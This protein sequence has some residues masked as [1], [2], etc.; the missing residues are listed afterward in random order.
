MERM[1]GKDEL[2]VESGMNRRRGMHKGSGFPWRGEERQSK[3]KEEGKCGM[4]D[5]AA[6]EEKIKTAKETITKS[7][8]FI[9]PFIRSRLCCR[10]KAAVIK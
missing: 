10:S 5:G 1:R 7:K 9:F 6:T 4:W 3:E 2:A 8:A